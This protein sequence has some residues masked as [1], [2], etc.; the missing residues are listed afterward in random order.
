[1]AL[2]FFFVSLQRA[3][4]LA[5]PIGHSIQQFLLVGINIP[6]CLIQLAQCREALRLQILQT[7]L[8][9]SLHHGA[10]LAGTQLGFQLPLN[11][12]Q[13][14]NTVYQLLMST[15][16]IPGL[17][18]IAARS[19]HWIVHRTQL[20]T[21]WQ[22][23]RWRFVL[24]DAPLVGHNLLCAVFRL[25]HRHAQGSAHKWSARERNIL[26]WHSKCR[27]RLRL[28]LMQ[29]IGTFGNRFVQ[30]LQGFFVLLRLIQDMQCFANGQLFLV[31]RLSFFRFDNFFRRLRSRLLRIYIFGRRFR[32]LHRSL[33]LDAEHG[34]VYA[35]RAGDFKQDSR[36]LF[37]RIWL[38]RDFL[39]D[40]TIKRVIL[41]DIEQR[42]N[43][44]VC[45]G[46]IILRLAFNQLIKGML[47]QFVNRVRIKNILIHFT[48][49]RA[50]ILVCTDFSRFRRLTTQI[51]HTIRTKGAHAGFEGMLFIAIRNNAQSTF[52][53]PQSQSFLTDITIHSQQRTHTKISAL[54]VIFFQVRKNEAAVKVH[55]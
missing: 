19:F 32:I 4:F 9:D 35:I 15:G 22:I 30:L 28:L 6:M 41:A 45:Q 49:I 21:S 39:A 12:I 55:R 2:E 25:L 53:G 24:A 5:Y 42:C 48:A 34:A 17:P 50:K 7:L 29:Q 23:L 26:L 43:C 27:F 51:H 31:N 11:S 10:C 14:Q 40:R 37:R 46:S 13:R 20:C 36:S 47:R 16:G 33:R 18:Q 38:F 3:D 44:L 52:V 1:M 8:K 54:N